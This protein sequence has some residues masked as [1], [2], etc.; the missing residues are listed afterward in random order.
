MACG[1]RTE[2]AGALGSI[3]EAPDSVRV[4]R[5]ARGLRYTGAQSSK[6]SGRAPATQMVW[7]MVDESDAEYSGLR[8][9]R[10]QDQGFQA[11]DLQWVL[12]TAQ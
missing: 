5:R 10:G 6:C 1:A 2:P 3:L 7:R 4:P 12:S 8:P 9:G 11:K